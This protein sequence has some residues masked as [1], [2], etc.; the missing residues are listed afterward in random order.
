VTAWTWLWLA[1]GAMFVAIEGA[2]LF[3][4]TPGDTLSEHFRKWFHTD[5]KVGRWSWIVVFGI[6]AAWFVTHIAVQGSA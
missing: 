1:W 4:K 2:A 5:N 3:N 6:F